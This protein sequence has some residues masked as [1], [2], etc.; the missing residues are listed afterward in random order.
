MQRGRVLWYKRFRKAAYLAVAIAVAWTLAAILPTDPFDDLL[1]VMIGGGAGTWLLLGYVTYLAVGVSGFMGLSSI[2]ASVEV[3]EGRVPNPILMT[4]G[5]VM[6]FAG[7]TATCLLLGIA[8][9]TGGYAQTLQ[10]TSW[11]QLESMLGPYVDVARVT[12]VVAIV[13]AASTLSGIAFAKG[14]TAV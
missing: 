7:V 13:G 14:G 10:H 1:P 5:I 9:A 8:G 6:L 3:G 12:S 11:D 4:A 2:L